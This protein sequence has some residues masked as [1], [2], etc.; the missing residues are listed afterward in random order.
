MFQEVKAEHIRHLVDIC[1]SYQAY[2]EA[3]R[4]LYHS[5]RGSAFWQTKKGHDYLVR[6]INGVTKS[7]GPR[8]AETE[9]T[10]RRFHER[11]R[12]LK[13][14]LRSMEAE[15]KELAAVSRAYRLQRVP[16]VAALVLRSLDEAG[17][18]GE[19]VRVVGTYALYAYEAMAGVAIDRHYLATVDVDLLFDV[20]RNLHLIG[21]SPANL[22]KLLKRADK[23]FML[24]RQRYRAI[25]NSG[26]MVD[27]I[28]PM[29]PQGPLRPQL[30][31]VR[32]ADAVDDDHHH[33]PN[34]VVAVDH[35]DE[36]DDLAAQPIEGL[37]W[38]EN[39]PS[40]EA[41]AVAD[42]GLPVRIATIDPRAFAAHKFWLAERLDRDR[43]KIRRDKAQA[44]MVLALIR[45]KLPM[46][47][48][49]DPVLSAL[50]DELRQHLKGR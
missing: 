2:A 22:L 46:L 44:E 29:D 45:E 12:D 27:L 23:S 3:K 11:R 48:L 8:S 16:K 25:N 21:N 28:A 6:K 13:N 49:E 5:Y 17:V 14:R 39:A 36:N 38:L 50:P 33:Q 19:Q 34:D 4:T 43:L 37:I 42:D 41:L 18:L 15:L 30:R 40:F 32:L 7:L 1:Q 47:K 20:R 26:Y 31:R 35:G 10:H 24:D 9:E